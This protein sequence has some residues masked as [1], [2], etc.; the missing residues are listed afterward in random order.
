MIFWAYNILLIFLA[1]FWVPWMLWRA[2][3]RDEKPNWRQRT[4]DLPFEPPAKGVRRAWVHAVS[5]GE[6]MA[7]L[8]V[9]REIRQLDPDLEIVL[10]TTTS[11]G[12]TAAKEKAEGLYDQLIYF[13]ID[14]PRFVVAAMI[15]VRP[16]VVAVMETE[17]WLN[18]LHFA[19]LFG[20]ETILINGRIS[21]RSYPRS[22]R[23]KPYYQTMFENLDRVLAQTEVDAQRFKDLG[24]SEPLVAGNTKFDGAVEAPVTDTDWRQELQIPDGELVTVIGSTRSEA[25]ERFIY[26]A[27][28]EAKPEGTV[29]HAPRHIER[30]DEIVERMSELYP[31][32]VV[33]R[34]TGC[35]GKYIVLDTY[36]ELGDVYSIADI[37]IVGGGFDDLGGQNILQ[38]LGKGVPVIH[39]KH[40]QNF[41]VAA[42]AADNAHAAVSVSEPSELC[43]WLIRLQANEQERAEMSENAKSLVQNSLGASKRCAEAVVEAAKT[44]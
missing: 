30:S 28:A 9:L 22:M 21:D 10:S 12:Q 32:E 5:V 24:F 34:S 31:G 44:E 11:S 18:F 23:I 6:V 13:P 41:S 25:E 8:P 27:F 43:F 33:K 40:M 7:A 38:P 37:A 1:P 19:K 36:G 35:A 29:I 2:K 15:R 3:K 26:E 42:S 4:G 20:A 39:G 16:K 14:V 17:L